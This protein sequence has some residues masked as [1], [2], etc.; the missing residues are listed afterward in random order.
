MSILDDLYMPPIRIDT[1]RL[2]VVRPLGP[3]QPSTE[4]TP[5]QIEQR[6]AA[7]LRQV[8]QTKAA[9]GEGVKR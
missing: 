2:R 4:L 5:A 1:E 7:R 8:G 6:R 9:N 3:F